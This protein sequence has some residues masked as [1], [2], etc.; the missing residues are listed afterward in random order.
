MTKWVVQLK[1]GDT[2]GNVDVWVYHKM[3]DS[4]GAA[5]DLGI[6]F[7][8]AAEEELKEMKFEYEYDGTYLF[9]KDEGAYFLI[10]GYDVYPVEDDE[11]A[12]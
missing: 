6:S 1:S 7:C 2:E 10:N 12:E 5:N 8:K 4:E 3:Y 9:L 11:D